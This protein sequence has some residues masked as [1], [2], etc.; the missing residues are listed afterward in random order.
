M[1]YYESLK[2]NYG[3]DYLTEQPKKQAVLQ[4][5]EIDGIVKILP[6]SNNRAVTI[7][8]KDKIFLQSYDTVILS[9]DKESKTIDKFWNDY[10][11]TTLKHINDF[12][13]PYGKKFNKKAWLAL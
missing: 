9:I 4:N 8:T 5:A 13:Q 11:V 7:E 10:S 12:L 1:Y 2:N 6:N 3:N